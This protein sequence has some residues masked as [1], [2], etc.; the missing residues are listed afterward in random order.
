MSQATTQAVKNPALAGMRDVGLVVSAS[1]FVALCAKVSLPLPFTPV[2]LTMSNFAVLLVGM[3][4]GPRR[5]GAALTLYLLEGASGL[6]VF[7]AGVGGVAQLFGPTGGYLFAYPLVA[8]I[9]GWLGARW[10]KFAGY[11]VAGVVAE[12]AL[13]A[14][15]FAWL[16]LA[17]RATPAQAATF[18]VA[19]FVFA[20][21]IKIML[22]AG[23][24]GRWQRVRR[25]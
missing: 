15:G 19:P 22:S 14:A 9:A 3:M 17:W 24:A 10:R 4:L 6:P 18:G 23:I 13:F 21:V 20:E 8:M 16:M 11:I 7:A 25:A 5:A 2:P 1:L 12:I